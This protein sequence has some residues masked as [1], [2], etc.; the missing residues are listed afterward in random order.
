MAAKE[1]KEFSSPDEAVR[2]L[3]GESVRIT[4]SRRISGGDINE[5]FGL[6]LSNGDTIFMKRNRKE[7]R[8]FFDTEIAGLLAIH[9][10]AAVGAPEILGIGTDEESHTS[11]LLLE[12]IRGGQRGKD[13]WEI[14]AKELAGMHRA[15]T[16]SFVPGG[17]YGFTGDNY[18]GAGPQKN[19][20]RDSWVDF[21]R[22]CRLIPQLRRAEGYFSSDD[23]KK[24]DRLLEHL[25]RYLTEPEKPSLL[26]GDLWSGNVITGNDG[27]AW[28]I[29]PAVYV[30]HA[31][32]DIAMTELFG[33]FSGAFYAAYKETGLMQPGYPERRD[34]YQLYHL[35]N[36]LNLF[37]GSYLHS[38]RRILQEY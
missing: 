7:N 35:L 37:G 20:V 3:F 5:A 14:F 29:D 2:L 32:T 13:Y 4:D 27:K 21:Y 23:R 36:H 34:L 24:A 31:E 15:G 12:F 33:G 8:S 22:D 25:D 6:S 9:Q 30:G 1:V 18:I 19:E 38:V 17:K 28:L 16:E 11:F 26:H 10:T